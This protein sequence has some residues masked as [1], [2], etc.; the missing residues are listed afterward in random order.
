M[1]RLNQLKDGQVK[2]TG[3]RGKVLDIYIQ[4]LQYI[5]KELPHDLM[6]KA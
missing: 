2:I 5:M 6:N 1:S 4:Q 3:P